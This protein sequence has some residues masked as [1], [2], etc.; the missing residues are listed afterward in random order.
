MRIP[1]NVGRH[2][3]EHSRELTGYTIELDGTRPAG[4][5]IRNRHGREK[6]PYKSNP[7]WML[8]LMEKGI[9]DANVMAAS[10]ILWMFVGPAP[11]SKHTCDHINRVPED[12]RIENLRWADDETQKTNRRSFQIQKL[13]I[14]TSELLEALAKDGIV[15][16]SVTEVP[17]KGMG[18]LPETYQG[19]GLKISLCGKYFIKTRKRGPGKAVDY[20]AQPS[21]RHGYPS[22]KMNGRH[23]PV[24]MMQFQLNFPGAARPEAVEHRNDNRL[25]AS[26]SNILGSTH[27]ANRISSYD[28]GCRDGTKTARKPVVL[29]DNRGEFPDQ[30]FQSAL[31]AGTWVTNVAA[32]GHYKTNKSAGKSVSEA[33][34]NS[35]WMV[36]CRFSV[37]EDDLPIAKRVKVE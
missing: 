27:S 33:A 29:R 35:T 5:I 13:I 31:S 32:P 26:A 30:C 17:A 21:I 28:N 19:L 7:Y 24:H 23:C 3:E 18:N 16:R 4:C 15:F 14:V 36:A 22:F 9:V 8:Q 12:N 34:R 6:K 10:L 20:M 25:D 11:S 2:T 1:I 37:R